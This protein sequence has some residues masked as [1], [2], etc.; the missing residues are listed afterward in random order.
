MR[1]DPAA[2]SHQPLAF[3]VV[4]ISVGALMIKHFT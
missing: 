3:S 4:T 1:L 2:L